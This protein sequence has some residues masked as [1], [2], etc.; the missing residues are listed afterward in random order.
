[1]DIPGELYF[2]LE[3]DSVSVK[4][5]GD[6][7][8]TMIAFKNNMIKESL[9]AQVSKLFFFMDKDGTMYDGTETKDTRKIMGQYI[10]NK[11]MLKIKEKETGEEKE[12][13]LSLKDNIL[14]MISEDK[15]K[16][17]TM[18]CRKKP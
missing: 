15:G 18:L 8:S 5:Q 6:E 12:I 1:M 11:S 10:E 3:T 14:T 13:E 2:N 4:L 17:L 7:D 9:K 16:K